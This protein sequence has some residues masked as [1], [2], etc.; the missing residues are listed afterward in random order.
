MRRLTEDRKT[1][2]KAGNFKFKLQ[3]LAV[4]I[5]E[6]DL[7]S[8]KATMH[9]HLNARERLQISL[10]LLAFVKL[11]YL[12]SKGYRI[13]VEIVLGPSKKRVRFST[14]RHSQTNL[15]FYGGTLL[16]ECCTLQ[17]IFMQEQ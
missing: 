6:D 5:G 8:F 12:A 14:A 16:L 4:H 17:P 7:G 10:V 13:V 15:E 1:K 9:S 11:A 3:Q 2:L